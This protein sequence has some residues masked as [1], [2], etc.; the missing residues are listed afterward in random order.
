MRKIS[1][2]GLF[3]PKS[4]VFNKTLLTMK[5]TVFLLTFISF[6]AYSG[7][8]YSQSSKISIPRSNLKV[9]ELLTNIES[10][11]DYL[12]VYN[13]QTVDTHRWVEVQADA[14]PVAEVLDQ[15]FENTDIRYVMEGHNIV[16]TK[17]SEIN[18]FILQQ[19]G[20]VTI[21]GTVTDQYGE[22]IIGANILEKGTTNGSITDLDGKFTITLSKGSVLQVT[23]IGYQPQEFTI[24]NQATINVQMQEEALTLDQVVVTA[25]GIKR[26]SSTLTYSVQQ[27][28]G[29]DLT[30]TKDANMI[31]SLQGKVAGVNITK[32][33]SG[34][35]GSA[36]V[37][38][39]GARSAVEGG[40]NQPLYV[41]DGVPMLNG[42]SKQAMTTMGG[43]NDA[44]NRDSGDGISNINSEDIESVSVL[45]GASASALYG[46]QAANGVIVITTKKGAAGVTR[47]S[48]SSSFTFDSPICL[49]EYQNS[50]D[51][52][53]KKVDNMKKYDHVGDFFSTGYTAINSVTLSTGNDKT[54]TYF[55]YA[56]TTARGVI[57]ANKLSKH[58]F[59]L[60]ETGA[61]FNERLTLDGNV[62]LLHQ[63]MRDRPVSGG[64]YLNPLV[65]LY[66]FPRGMDMTPYKS[67]EE[68]DKRRNMNRQIWYKDTFDGMEGNPYWLVNR[69][70]SQERRIRTI[71]SLTANLKI[72]SWF[73][74]Q[75]RGNADYI[76][77]KFEQQ[78]W[79]STS[80]TLC[81][82]DWEQETENG[83]YIY[84]THDEFL[85]YGDAM[86][87]FNKTWNNVSLNAVIG[88]ALNYTR[89]NTYEIDSHLSGLYKP[90]VFTPTNVIYTQSTGVQTEFNVQREVQSVFGTAQLGYDEALYLDLT[91]RNDWSSTLY[92]TEK[93][94]S[95]YFYPSIGVSW[96]M[97][98]TLQMPQW[99]SFAKV[100]GSF[101]EVGNDLP[102]YQANLQPWLAAGGTDRQVINENDGK[103]KPELS[104]SWEVG[105][106]LKLFNSR[107]DLDFTWYTTMTRNQFLLV[108][109]K[110]GSAYQNRMVNAGKIRNRGI[111][112]TIGG[113]P[114]QT[115]DFSWRT[116]VNLATNSNKVIELA[117]HLG[118]TSFSY[119]Q[120]GLNMAYRMLVKEGGSLG[121]IYGNTYKR[122]EQ[123]KIMFGEDGL[124]LTNSDRNQYLGNSNPDYTLGWS[125]S[126]N[127]HGISVNILVDARVGGK[128]MSFTQ[129]YMD[130]RGV[131][132]RVGEAMDRKYVMLEGQKIEDVVGFYTMVGDKDGVTEQYLYDA[133]NVR[134]RELSIGYN[135]PQ[136]WLEKTKF[137]KGVNLSLVGRN[138]FFF[139]KDAPFDP[140]A[141]LSVG[142][143]N[144]GVDVFGM[145]TTRSLGFNVKFTF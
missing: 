145:P 87:T 84:N 9:G 125:N 8:G 63:T 103:L 18:A 31:N 50:Y 132:K 7:N 137:I 118:Y 99:I 102:I 21:K 56:N 76:S 12:F 73:S 85:V 25:M 29:D 34:L 115:N 37:S 72:N 114:I 16:L 78:M 117:P 98:K 32:N 22:P 112:L 123:G 122:N 15:A 20:K 53:W 64:L 121:D 90:N 131:S 3:C 61:F 97:H 77:D 101:T 36:K 19:Q 110:P 89:A 81:G 13:K 41:I 26:K 40:N 104:D 79:A 1:L 139:Y 138:L 6:Q 54:Q 39:R 14:T 69:V 67:G 2:Q 124:P 74:L 82:G 93:V 83:R 4:L 48:F 128:T 44:G 23:Y 68:Y 134:L 142:N 86:A 135:L 143:A 141:T 127:F 91:F 42:V 60:R 10:Q 71:A 52:N 58:N 140:D 106:E 66:T 24:N 59:T 70:T 35:G 116:Q 43:D 136:L 11:T 130:A 30:R 5:I 62:N 33:A 144:Q 111:E 49:P 107:V 46:S 57:D 45:K 55:S 38:I 100:R 133:T 47:A 129:G 126:F 17:N 75:A 95:G 105:A 88:G 113:Y 109:T 108:P 27:V 96:L 51:Q 65:G 28:G 120:D 94:S 119:G 80:R 92:G